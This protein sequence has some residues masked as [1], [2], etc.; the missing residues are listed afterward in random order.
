MPAPCRWIKCPRCGQRA[1]VSLRPRSPCTHRARRC[2][3]TRS[4]A[5]GART[6]THPG[7]TLRFSPAAGSSTHSA[8]PTPPALQGARVPGPGSR[9]GSKG[10]LVGVG[11]SAKLTPAASAELALPCRQPQGCF[12]TPPGP[13]PRSGA[14][15]RRPVPLTQRERSLGPRRSVLAQQ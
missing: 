2:R 13:P 3:G 9:R 7:G 5:G 11:E 15:D 1:D 4:A 14:R 10:L 8:P 6:S 12:P